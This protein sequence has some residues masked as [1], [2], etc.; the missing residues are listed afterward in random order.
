[1]KNDI[2]MKTVLTVIAGSLLW[3]CFQNARLPEAVLA[4]TPEKPQRVVITDESGSPLK[5]ATMSPQGVNLLA[6]PVFVINK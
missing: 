5:T 4:A 1:M 6:L 3:L 2:Y